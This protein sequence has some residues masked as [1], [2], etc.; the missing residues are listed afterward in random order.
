M[1]ATLVV[2]FVPNALYL[3]IYGK[4]GGIGDGDLIDIRHDGTPVIHLEVLRLEELPIDGLNQVP[5]LDG[6]S[7]GY[8]YGGVFVETA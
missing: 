1:Y 5:R 6:Y 7:S 4:A 3:N 8:V 2:I